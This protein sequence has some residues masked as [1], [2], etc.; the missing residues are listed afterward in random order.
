MRS[1]PLLALVLLARFGP[2]ALG[3]LAP[4]MAVW[5]GGWY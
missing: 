3:H 1:C 5:H 2:L 4:P